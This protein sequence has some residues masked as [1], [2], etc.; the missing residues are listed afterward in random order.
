MVAIRTAR[1]DR[2]D[3]IS[4]NPPKVA[5]EKQ[6][7]A[8]GV[9]CFIFDLYFIR[10]LLR[11][12]VSLYFHVFIF[13]Y[14][15]KNQMRTILFILLLWLICGKGALAQVSISS[16]NTLPEESAMLDVNSTSKGFLPPRMTTIQ[17]NAIASPVQGLVIFNTDLNCLE[18]FTGTEDGWN[19]PCLSQADADCDG[20]TVNGSYITGVSLGL[21]N[22]VTIG[23][24]VFAPGGYHFVTGTVNGY[25]FSARGTFTATGLQTVI[26]RGAGTPVSAG[27][28]DFIVCA[29]SEM[30]SFTVTVQEAPAPQLFRSGIFLH[31]STGL[32]IWGPN[33]SSTSVPQEMTAYNSAHGYTGQEAV[34][35]NEEWW[36]PGD[37]EWVT[38]HE[39]FEDPSPVTGIGSY[40]PGNKIIVI[41]SCFPASSMSGAGQPSDTLNPWMKTIWNYKWHWRHIVQVMAAN[42][43]NFFVIWTNAPLEQYSTNTSEAMYSKQFC[44]WAKDT[45]AAGLD[46]VFGEF[47]GNV[48]VFDFFHKLT[49]TDGIMLS[50]YAASP[51]D[52]H[53]NASATQLVAPQ[54]V[55][56][57]FDAAI[58]YEAI[59][60]RPKSRDDR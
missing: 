5:G 39:F 42:P 1:K 21:G 35:M 9:I 2:M 22:T 29:G 31:H 53:P 45:L 20:L 47:P 51:G 54:F 4:G 13:V 7:F 44:A 56:E 25:R 49:G 18:F 26:L 52:S 60:P 58:A 37:N 3:D 46:P 48:Y 14:T 43:D 24:N 40:L 55:Q 36:S 27:M 32:N 59:A 11:K 16:G 38:Q 15:K 28:D 34:A 23:V 50:G 10:S 57:I 41:K 17:R 6:F 8:I 12:R 30:C 33:G 19:C